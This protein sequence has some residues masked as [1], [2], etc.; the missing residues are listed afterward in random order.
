MGMTDTEL[1]QAAGARIVELK[2]KKQEM[3]IVQQSAEVISDGLEEL[4]SQVQEAL[5]F[6][7]EN[8]SATTPDYFDKDFNKNIVASI[9]KVFTL[10]QKFKQSEIKVDVDLSPIN[11]LAAEIKKSNE[12]IIGLLSQPNQSNEVVRMLGEMIGKQSVIFEGL[13]RETN[14][15]EKLDSIIEALNKNDGKVMEINMVYD[16]TGT[17]IRKVI[18]IYKNSL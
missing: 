15:S 2:D 1:L 13:T 6:F 11:S 7:K 9:D 17:S 10:L 3:S 5:K 14:Y 12:T 18:P 8:K 4:A 16:Q